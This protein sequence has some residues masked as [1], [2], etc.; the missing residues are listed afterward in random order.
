MK[1]PDMGEIHSALAENFSLTRGG[2]LYRL[3]VRA[4]G[5]E[6]ER[7]RIAREALVATLVTWL[8]LF[9]F[10][11]VQGRAYGPQITMPFLEDIAVNVRFL[12]ALPILILS[13]SGIHERWRMLVLEFLRTRLIRE[14]ELPSF[15]AAIK[16]ITRLRDSVIPE[17]VMLMA[18]YYPS[19]FTRVE[20]LGGISTWHS[21]GTSSSEMSL[22][23]WWFTWVATPLIRFLLLRWLWRLF[24]WTWLLWRVSRI[25][26]H[27]IATHTDMAAGLGFL[28]EGQK[29]FAPIVFAGG[30]V[31]AGHIGNTILYQGATLSSV[32][33]LMIAYA[34]MAI[35]IL[36]APLFVVAPALVKVRRK[37]LIEYGGLVTDNAQ[38]FDAKWIHGRPPLGEVLLGNADPSSLYDLGASFTVVRGM[39]IVPIDRPTLIALVAAAALPM[40][41]VV[42]FATP[43]DELVRAVLK[44]L[45]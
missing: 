5:A 45:G 23:G 38:S 30:A 20:L 18:A 26:L 24:L 15:E 25:N 22:A 31:V 10:S 7:R 34:V 32:S 28:S 14:A 40:L 41:A 9:I 13:E 8:P 2:L 12:L 29:A 37:A 1:S 35:T 3:L 42:L 39:G 11:L 6:R 44:M 4:S 43:A 33:H 17:V 16:R 36:I 21:M 19:F 27:L